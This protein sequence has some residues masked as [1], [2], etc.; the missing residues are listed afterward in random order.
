MKNLKQL[1]LLI[2]AFLMATATSAQWVVTPSTQV[3]SYSQPNWKVDADINDDYMAITY[4]NQNPSTAPGGTGTFLKIY[5]SSS[6]PITG[7]ISV[8]NMGF[9]VSRVKISRANIIYVLGTNDYSSVTKLVLK[10]FNTTGTLLG[11]TIVHHAIGGAMFD[12]TITDNDDVL[13]SLFEG[14]NLKIRSYSSILTYKGIISVANSITHFH[15][16]TAN[17]R[18]Q[19]IDFKAG[20]ILIGYSRGVDASLTSFI[21]KYNYNSGTP[22]ASAVTGT[23]PFL[24]GFNRRNLESNNSHQVALRANGDIFYING[25]SGVKRIS[26][27]TTATINGNTKTK[28]SVDANDNVLISWT[29]NL[30]ARALLYNSSNTFVH[31]YLE[32]GNINGSWAPAFYN[33]SFVIAGDKSNQGTDYHTNRKPHYQV[34]NCSNC[35]VGGAATASAQFKYPY[36]T[37]QMNSFYGPQDVAELCLIDDLLVDGSASCNEDGYFVE[38]AEF[39]LLT[40]TD[41]T[42]LHSAWVCTGCQV[43]NNI[44]ITSFLP[45][46]YQLRPDKIYR[47][48]LAVGSPWNSTNIFFKVSCCRRKII[49]VPG[50]VDILKLD[51]QRPEEEVQ[52]ELQI[53]VFPNPVKNE[54]T[55]DFSK[56]ERRSDISISIRNFAGEELFTAETNLEELKID[57]KAWKKGIYLC[58]ITLNG[59]TI[60]KRIVKQ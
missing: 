55:L 25:I 27:S 11:T 26:G 42:V 6:T 15:L 53:G 35:E 2:V 37:V 50:E 3:S 16:P 8:F 13:V 12:L 29:D 49:E 56:E 39:D 58:T 36:Q 47:F 17:L 7:D 44:D 19:F 4:G 30:K 34:F 48:K 1:S 60:T 32:D 22:A 43:P 59:K 5:N 41:V 9:S 46:G 38:L 18:S 33:C 57:M 54:V 28:V 21:K 24:G 14:D 10:R 51:I 45:Q 40:W 52:K 20:S 31:S 23:Y